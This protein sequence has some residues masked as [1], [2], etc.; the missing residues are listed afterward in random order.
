DGAV[1]VRTLDPTLESHGLLRFTLGSF[2][3]FGETAQATGTNGTVGYAVSLHRQTT[4]GETDQQI[5]TDTGE[6]A[7]VGSAVA[8][9]TALAKIRMGIGDG[10]G[11]LL[12]TL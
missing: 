3:T 11:S 1:N 4:G 2:S 6:T 7:S 5:T 10:G 9:D 12:L 8:G